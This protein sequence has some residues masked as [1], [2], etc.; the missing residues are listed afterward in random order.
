MSEKPIMAVIGSGFGGSVMACRLA[1]RQGY[2]VH[3][4]ERGR[5]YRQNEFPRRPDQLREAFW[6]PADGKFG[7]FEYR[8]FA[9]TDIDVWTASGLGG[10]SLIY[11][12]VLYE[13]PPEFFEG[14]PAGITRAVLDPYYERVSAMMEAQPY[15]LDNPYYADTPKTQALRRAYER[16]SSHPL[17]H[18]A[19]RLEFPK[20]AIQFGP[21]GQKPNHQGVMQSNCIRCGEC[22]IGCN[23]HAKNTLDL[24]YLARAEKYGATL[25]E[26]AEVRAVLPEAGGE[27]FR[28]KYF[29]P[30]EPENLK[31]IRAR[32][33]IV[34][35][36]SL[37]STKLL[38]RMRDSA[39]LS[40]LS[41]ALGTQWSGNGD[42]LGLCLNSADP[43]YP[44]TGPVITAAVR[45][46]HGSYPDGFPHGL[47]VEDAGMPNLL[48]WYVTAM[49]PAWESIVAEAKGALLYV[50]G[51]L[52]PRREVNMAKELGPL[53]FQESRL[54]SRT[55][56]FLGMGRDRSTGK[57]ELE[58]DSSRPLQWWEDCEIRL[59]WDV[60]PSRLHFDRLRE[61]MERLSTELGGEF[62]E[63]PLS[64]LNKYIA[65][66]PL[67][68][69]PM[70]DTAADGVV[71]AQSGQV[72][73][74]PGLYVV[75]GSIIP[76]AIGPNP[77]LTIAALAERFAERFP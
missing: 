16:L 58:K 14:W 73:G 53:L 27:G 15:P 71:D 9:E 23:Y 63:N 46:F 77:S 55:L 30:G 8:S 32:Y 41:T 52:W 44:S 56:P 72:F 10:G 61:G 65:V 18:A 19:A 64:E 42:M 69:C 76:T 43:I 28:V 31:E 13:M 60:E 75:D 68:G 12:N 67:G 4:F 6:D 49:S 50:L 39:Q 45:F 35:A 37:G 26:R 48:A 74:H 3:V 2:E 66:H 22:D 38:L 57:M 11:A 7:M 59:T 20:L 70:A 40:N 62:L 34:S 5:R 21:P 24:N 51:F 54:V 25:H 1:E 47:F 17:G 36:G 33:V 29:S